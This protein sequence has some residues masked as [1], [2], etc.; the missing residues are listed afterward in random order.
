M[1]TRTTILAIVCSWSLTVFGQDGR[2][3]ENISK[4][5]ENK[6]LEY[7]ADGKVKTVVNISKIEYYY[8]WIKTADTVSF[9]DQITSWDFSSLKNYCSNYRNSSIGFDE[10]ISKCNLIA[11]KLRKFNAAV[12]NSDS[13][14]VAH[15]AK[16]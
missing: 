4:A 5:N 12:L 1:K 2:I 14:Q 7:F 15:L 9:M 8:N 10:Q 16:N 11:E 3:R 13:I 6:G